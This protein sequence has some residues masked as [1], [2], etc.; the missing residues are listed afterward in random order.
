M[1]AVQEFLVNAFMAVPAVSGRELGRD[2]EA[3]VLLGLLLASRPVAVQAV[4][5]FLRMPAQLVF[6][7]HR[8]LLVVVAFGAFARRLHQ[9]GVGLSGFTARP[10]AVD[11]ETMSANAMTTETNTDRNDIRGVYSSR[12]ATMICLI[13]ALASLS[14]A[15]GA[16]EKNQPPVIDPNSNRAVDNAIKRLLPSSR[17]GMQF[18][19]DEREGRCYFIATRPVTPGPD[20]GMVRDIPNT[21]PIDSMP[22]VKPG[23]TCRPPDLS[24]RPPARP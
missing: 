14:L 8:I 15:G 17:D 2:H 3:V 24:A 10:L 11:Q 22:V 9:G 23:P 18:K 16:D 20:Q 1:P 21:P 13:F 19:L 4:H 12:K 6:V 7:D 5:L